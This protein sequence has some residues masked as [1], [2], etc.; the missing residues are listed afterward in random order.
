MF[1]EFEF[2]WWAALGA[3]GIAFIE[4]SYL[5][6]ISRLWRQKSANDISLFFPG[7]NLLGRVCAFAYALHSSIEVFALGFLVGIALRGT[8]FC[9]VIWYRNLRP[10]LVE[11]RINVPANA[12]T[13]IVSG[14]PR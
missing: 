13:T 12:V 10:Y 6:Q 11:R 4:I 9:Q 1:G 8:L 5:P 3:M 2:T 14:E 7:L